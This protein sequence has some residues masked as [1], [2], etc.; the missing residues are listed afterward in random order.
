MGAARFLTAFLIVISAFAWSIPA[1]AGLVVDPPG[2]RQ[3]TQPAIP[4]GSFLRT[5]ETKS[6]FDKKY[7]KIRDLIT[8]DGALRA[9]IRRVAA[10]YGIDPIHIVGALVGEHTYNVDVYDRLQ[11]YYIKAISYADHRFRFA[12]GGETVT[13]F[14]QRPQFASCASQQGSWKKWSCREDVWERNFRG[15]VVGG[16]AFPD[17]RFSA[18][19]FQP[20]YAGQTFGLGQINPLTALKLTDI[21]HRVSGYA[22]LDDRHAADVYDAIM[23]PDKSLAYVAAAIREFDRG[24][25]LDRRRGYFAQSGNYGHTVQRRYAGSTGRS[26]GSGEQATGRGGKTAVAAPGKLLWLACERPPQGPAR[27]LR[28]QLGASIRTSVPGCHA[29]ANGSRPLLTACFQMPVENRIHGRDGG[30]V[31]IGQDIGKPVGKE[32]CFDG[33][34]GRVDAYA[35]LRKH[36]QTFQFLRI[37]PNDVEIADN[38]LCELPARSSATTMLESREIGCRHAQRRGHLFL[39]NAALGPQAAHRLTEGR[40]VL[41]PRLRLSRI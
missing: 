7:E 35:R 31:Q 18:V 40:H 21:V 8:R 2:N 14:V 22:K 28:R 36:R 20:F 24:L 26:S 16:E 13:H 11:S 23:D 15:R 4:R 1:R 9:K 32:P 41:S 33:E 3:A 27:S 37:V 5:W 30:V 17:K 10:T 39:R 12:Y 34:P 29:S 38:P 25:P 19:F 6:S